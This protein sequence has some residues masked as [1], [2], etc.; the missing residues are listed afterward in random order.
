MGVDTIAAGAGAALVLLAALSGH[1]SACG[2]DDLPGDADGPWAAA[3]AAAGNGTRTVEDGLSDGHEQVDGLHEQGNLTVN[4]A[5]WTVGGAV[6][7][8]YGEA[9]GY[10]PER[11]PGVGFEVQDTRMGP[12]PL[13]APP[14][15]SSALSTRPGS[16]DKPPAPPSEDKVRDKMEDV[17]SEPPSDDAPE[18]AALP[19]EHV[20]APSKEATQEPARRD[21]VVAAPAEVA[22]PGPPR[23]QAA[24]SRPGLP[25]QPLLE[26]SAIAGEVP[27]AVL[28]TVAA[29]G[30]SVVALVTW[31]LLQGRVITRLA[32]GPLLGLFS[33]QTG[34]QVLN[35]SARATVHAAITENPGITSSALVDITGCTPSVLRYHVGV[36]RREGLIRVTSGAKI[37]HYHDA[38][39]VVGDQERARECLFWRHRG[40]L[41]RAILEHPG[42]TQQE[43]A[44]LAG[45]PPSRVCAYTR[46]LSGAGLVRSERQGRCRRYFPT[47]LLESMVSSDQVA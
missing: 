18:E 20:R 44:R 39:R 14:D 41:A 10:W 31:I 42:A 5:S 34:R 2:C 24:Q 23:P 45:L 33:R 4:E 17:L 32:A 47:A 26:A 11:T 13:P 8:V 43:V 6:L 30:L 38:R 3:G 19:L 9:V 28:V 21:P 1:A 35:H 12:K 16:S 22:E 29:A 36:L 15:P 25:V 7:A 37:H 46:Q 27:P 40:W